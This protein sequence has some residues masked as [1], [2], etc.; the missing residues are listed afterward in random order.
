MLYYIQINWM[1]SFLFEI[2]DIQKKL[3]TFMNIN[4]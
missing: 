4:F 2:I 1:I 3:N